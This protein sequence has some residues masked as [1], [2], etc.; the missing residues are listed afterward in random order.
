MII[1][2][3][4]IN[5]IAHSSYLLGGNKKCAIVDPARDIDMYL[6]AAEEMGLEITHILET[7]LHADFVSGHIDLAEETGAR[8]YA[9]RSGKCN[10][11]HEA[12]EGGDSFNIEDMKIDVIETPGHTPESLCY[13]VT[14]LGRGKDPV[15]LFSGDTLFVGDVG[16]P[17]LFPG[18]A[19]EL[20]SDLFDSI[21]GKILK[22]PDFCE[23]YP[24]HGAGSLCGRAMGAKRTSTV[25]YER[26]YN[27]ALQIGNRDEFIKSL[28]TGMPAA[29]DHFARCSD[30][31]RKGPEPASELSVMMPLAPV[32]VKDMTESGNA[33][34]L[35]CRSFL[36]FGGAHIP[37][38]YSIDIGGNFATFAGW[39]IPPDRRIILVS[40][41]ESQAYEA[42]V[43]L[44]RV[45]L[46]DVAGYLEGGMQRW[47]MA[48]LDTSG[49]CQ[50]SAKKLYETAL[51]NMPIN[52]VDVRA[53]REFNVY[54][55]EGAVNIPVQ[56]LRT[57]YT[58][59]D[60][61]LPTV[62]VCGS[63]QRSGIGASLLQQRG[64]RDVLNL[65]GGMSGFAASGF[66]PT[67]PVCSAPHG[68]GFPG[69]E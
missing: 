14:D 27:K 42:L 66:A 43:W 6:E 64:F 2:Q 52:I 9:P 41:D 45:G 26:K 23:V 58:E 12:L 47:T 65:A 32:D 15:A 38:A 20:A 17:D 25:G 10:F 55:I 44:R 4:F 37:G 61:N 46:D 34:V 22:L 50:I 54:H 13:V 51:G 33:V 31:N 3:F 68:P 36:A 69:A 57:R 53:D 40:S 60:P 16:R 62:T 11:D 67:C 56:D 39:I 19:E 29:P 1:R 7:H 8:I 49:I 28:T 48:G 18:R 5:G 21:H 30:I 24:A 59:L 63:G 35:D